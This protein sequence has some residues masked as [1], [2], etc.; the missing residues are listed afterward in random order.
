MGSCTEELWPSFNT[1]ES[2]GVMKREG[3]QEELQGGERAEGSVTYSSS[4]CDWP[5]GGGEG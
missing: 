3:T 5:A 2:D 4:S 1:R